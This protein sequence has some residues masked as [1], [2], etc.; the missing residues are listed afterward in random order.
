[1]NVKIIDTCFSHEKYSSDQ[2]P[3]GFEQVM[4]WD[5]NDI[6][7]NN[8]LIVTDNHLRL[9]KNKSN[10]TAWTIESEAISPHVYN[11][12]VLNEYNKVY[13]HN[14]RLL[15]IGAKYTFVPVGGCW[16]KPHEQFIYEKT[17]LISI[18]ASNKTTTSGHK[19]RHLAVDKNKEQIDV[20]G[21]QYKPIENKILGL[22]DYMFQIVI[23]NSKYDYYFTEKLIDCF[24]TGTIPIYWGCPSIGDFFDE[25]G[26]IFFDNVEELS[27]IIN[28]LNEEEYKKRINSVHYNFYEADKYLLSEKYMIENNLIE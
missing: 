15:D 13:T 16:I 11:Q 23:E 5:R 3:N 22:K 17:K 28:K 4:V 10:K 9:I 27:N 8:S 14:K 1:M 21:R 6:N 12:S 20:Y 19:L 18:I 25:N 7:E 2:Y 24:K 26:L